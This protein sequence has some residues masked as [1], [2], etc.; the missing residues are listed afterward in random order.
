MIKS[1]Q[2]SKIAPLGALNPN[3]ETPCSHRKRDTGNPERGGTNGLRS[4]L[5]NKADRI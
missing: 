2:A 4:G 1:V 3:A 5:G